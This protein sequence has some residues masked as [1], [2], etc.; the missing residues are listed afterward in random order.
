[1][2]LRRLQLVALAGAT[3]GCL[4]WAQN[5]STSQTTTQQGTGR[6]TASASASSSGSQ[7]AKASG[8]Q[9]GGGSLLARSTLAPTHAIFYAPG[10][11]WIEGKGSKEQPLQDHGQYMARLVQD[12]ILIF[13]GP[14]RDEHGIM[15]LIRAK[16]DEQARSVMENDPGVRNGVLAGDIKAWE[17]VFQGIGYPTR[18]AR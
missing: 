3:L 12:G 8:S 10:P 9:S 5:S 15:V 6:A 13:A 17:V 4:A 18:Q 7:G 2:T 1:M 16:S 14:W 11:N